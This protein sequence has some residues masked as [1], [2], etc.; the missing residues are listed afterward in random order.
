MARGP[1]VFAAYVLAE[2]FCARIVMQG[3]VKMLPQ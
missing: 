1:G 3:A 2:E